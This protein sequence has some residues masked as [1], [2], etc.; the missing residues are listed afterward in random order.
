MNRAAAIRTDATRSPGEQREPR[1]PPP[2]TDG[3]I[4]HLLLTVIAAALLAGCATGPRI[5]ANEDPAAEFNRYRTYDFASPL[6]TDRAEYSSLLTEYLRQATARELEARGYTRA[7]NPDL[8]INFYVNT[9]ERIRSTSTMAP[10]YGYY[11]YRRGYYGVW[12]GYETTVTQY[13]EG[14]LTIDVVDRARNQLVWEGTAVGRTREEDRENL[15]GAVD[16]VVA[17]VFMEY[18]YRAP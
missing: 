1:F 2:A 10:G 4:L 12:G 16:E 17:L 3:R 13:T 6:G 9:R 7:R 8:L 14:T 18:P 11:G 15:K 5:F